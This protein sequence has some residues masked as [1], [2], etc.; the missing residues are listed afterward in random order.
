MNRKGSLESASTKAKL[1]FFSDL[2]TRPRIL[3]FSGQRWM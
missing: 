3:F 1:C 2:N